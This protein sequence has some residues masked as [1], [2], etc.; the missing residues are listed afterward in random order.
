[1]AVGRARFGSTIT[2]EAATLAFGVL[3]LGDHNISGGVRQFDAAETYEDLKKTLAETFSR[4]DTPGMINAITQAFPES[5]FSLRTLFRDEQRKIVNNVLNDSLASASAAYREIFE[6]HAPLIHFL[7]NLG[8]PIPAA[9]QSA[10]EIALNSQLKQ[11]IERPELDIDGIQSSLKEAAATRVK[12]DVS[13]L[14]Y[15]LRTRLEKEADAFAGQPA[16]IDR[17][18]SFRKL[19]EFTATLPFPVNLWEVQNF[20]FRPLIQTMD[21][22]RPQAEKDDAAARSTLNELAMIRKKLHIHA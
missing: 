6:N 13:G 3:H 12:L 8:I 22:L 15:A 5:P 17:A 1:M 14:E 18:Q 4:A 10:A 11:A 2:Q 20:C 16:D 9:F 19:L 7:N 21:E